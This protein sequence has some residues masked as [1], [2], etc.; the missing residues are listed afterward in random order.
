MKRRACVLGGGNSA[1][2]T[3]G[4]IAGQPDW[5]CNIYADYGDEAERI[6][7]GA[8][9][10]GIRVHYGQQDGGRVV[11]GPPRAVSR[12]ASEVVPGCELLILCMSAQGY[13]SNA[14]AIAAHVDDGAVIG[15]I[16]G[17]NG[18]DWC[19][20]EAMAA[21][22][23]AP[24]SYDVFAMQNLP[25]A[26]RVEKP[27]L[28]VRVLGAK[29]FMEITARP[30][31]RASEIAALIGELIGMECPLIPGGFLGVGLSNICQ[32]IHPAVMHDNFKDWD[33]ESIF[34]EKPLFYQGLSEEA[35]DSMSRVSDEI[36]A[37]R[38]VLEE[39]C[40]GL[41]LGVVHH[42]FEW[43]LRAYGEYIS[44]RSTLRTRFASNSAYAG[45]ACPM[46]AS[47]EGWAPDL[48][49]RY[50]A[51]D[52]PYNLLAVR[53]IA[54][55]AGVPTPTIDTLIDWSQKAL[56]KEWLVDGRV[57]GKDLAE[58]FAPQRFGFTALG[59]IPELRGKTQGQ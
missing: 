1:H 24:D 53:G 58:T 38:A 17:S 45:L 56:G 52:V 21:V 6:Q 39:R 3:A 59:D 20:D 27:G 36:Q 28:D 19:I 51:E 57:S 10:G 37:A 4:L 47:G 29:P 42:V 22:G 9:R 33:G 11:H 55:L 5:E 7:A 32:V 12:N 13:D 54:E 14:R 25:W 26:C 46:V 8:R 40:Q 30:G 18:F 16:C 48:H 41:D 15:T 44:D 2:V 35:A 34:Q 50:L 31:A 23:R 43:T 49:A